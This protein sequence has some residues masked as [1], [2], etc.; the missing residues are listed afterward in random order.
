[1]SEFINVL[2]A[3][4]AET[5]V[6][7]LG[8]NTDPDHPTAVPNS[9]NLIYMTTRHN[10]L[11]GSPGS[12][13]SVS[14]SPTDIIRWRETTLSLNSSYTGILYRFNALGGGDLISTPVPRSVVL[15]EPLPDS[16]NPLNPGTQEV[17]SYY[18]ECEVLKTGRVTYN[19]SFMILNRKGEKQG[20]YFWDPFINIRD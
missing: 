12:E 14:A 4:D 5:I 9:S 2:I 19:F 15:H 11:D 16:G 3:I 6:E 8:K 7:Q 20:Y 13:L 18:W 10:Q 1:M 17:N